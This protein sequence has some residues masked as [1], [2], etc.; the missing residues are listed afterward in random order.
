MVST[1][2]DVARDLTQAVLAFDAIDKKA[3]R[4]Q[5]QHFVSSVLT[6]VALT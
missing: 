6:A 5:H 3:L 1:A 4:T 2:T